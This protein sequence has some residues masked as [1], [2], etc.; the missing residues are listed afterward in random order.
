M[1]C[2]ASLACMFLMYSPAY[3]LFALGY[4]MKALSFLYALSVLEKSWNVWDPSAFGLLRVA[5]CYQRVCEVPS[6]VMMGLSREMMLG[7]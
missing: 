3:F 4:I 6:T 2:G 7:T 1:K 5:K